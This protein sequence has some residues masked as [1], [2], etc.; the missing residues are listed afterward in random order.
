MTT[1]LL[2]GM[3]FLSHTAD[4]WMSRSVGA[5]QAF[6]RGGSFWTHSGLYLGDGRVIEGEP[7]GATIRDVETKLRGTVLWSDAPIQQ[8]L[9]RIDALGNEGVERELR[10]LVVAEALKL[11]GTPYSYADYLA[12]AAVEWRW[13]GH[14]RLRSYVE[15]SGRLICSALVDRAYMNAGVHL[16]SDGRTPGDVTPGD[17][18]RY[19]QHWVR[20]R[21]GA[22]ESR[23]RRIEDHLAATAVQL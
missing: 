22:M 17:L 11:E 13:P 9:A 4:S 23:I 6:V 12:I 10:E 21:L 7:G 5:A 3:F 19:D 20:S 16:Y 14:E 1:D 15:S 18:D 8:E 2:P